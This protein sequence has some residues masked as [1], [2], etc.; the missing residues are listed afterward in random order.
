MRRQGSQV[1]MR[2]ARVE[3]PMALGGGRSQ[4]CS[5][6]PAWVGQP[7]SPSLM[8]LCVRNAYRT[9]LWGRALGKLSM[10]SP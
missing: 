6:A 8:P 4:L 1:S 7:P 2:V 5:R 3:I 9:W 10:A